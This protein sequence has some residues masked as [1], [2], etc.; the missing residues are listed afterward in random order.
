MS[1]A[2]DDAEHRLAVL[3]NWALFAPLSLGTVA[4]AFRADSVVMAGAGYAMLVAGA[5]SHL[6]INRIYRRDF[7][8]GEVATAISLF[9]VAV[10]AFLAAWIFPPG[11]TPI[12]V[13]IG[14]GGLAVVVVGFV[15]YLVARHGMTGAFSMFHPE[16]GTNGGRPG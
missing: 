2:E 7:R 6:V 11:L 15:V 4:T 16:R 1:E 8:P 14:L 5:I 12:G 3:T 10:L 13:A 9:G